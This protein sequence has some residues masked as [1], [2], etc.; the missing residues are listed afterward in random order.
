MEALDNFIH[1]STRLPCTLFLR[2]GG[3]D[4]TVQATWY[5]A[6]R[7]AL[8]L[9]GLRF[10]EVERGSVQL[11]PTWGV[12]P[13]CDPDRTRYLYELHDGTDRHRVHIESLLRLEEDPLVV[14]QA[15]YLK[16]MILTSFPPKGL[17]TTSTSDL[18][19]LFLSNLR[20]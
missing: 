13:I 19:S 12:Q 14:E 16:E 8:D 9:R 11:L 6:V 15:G 20:K 2:E 4:E 18:V 17:L 10:L 1:V 7:K 5:A 3:H